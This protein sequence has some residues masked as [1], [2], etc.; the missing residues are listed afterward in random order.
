MSAMKTSVYNAVYVAVILFVV[1]ALCVI[2]SGCTQPPS[3]S[4]PQP[5]PQPTPSVQSININVQVSPTPVQDKIVDINVNGQHIHVETAG[6]NKSVHVDQPGQS[7]IDVN[8]VNGK[9]N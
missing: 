9:M 3:Q 1:V 4:Q 5:T 2:S 8:I 6:E 7:P